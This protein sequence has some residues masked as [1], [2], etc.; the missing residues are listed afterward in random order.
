M[1]SNLQI[2]GARIFDGMEWHDDA[3]LVVEAGRTAT[4]VSSALRWRPGHY[5]RG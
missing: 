4:Q 5:L 1:S 3:A 2:K